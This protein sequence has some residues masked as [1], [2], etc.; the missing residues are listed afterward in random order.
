MSI[1]TKHFGYKREKGQNPY[2]GF[3]SF[4]HFRGE[5]LYSDIVVDPCGNGTETERVECYPVSPDAEE[6]GREQGYYPDST[7]VYIRILW[8]EFEPK[9]GEY[10]YKFIEEI[11]EK[12]K[13]S[14]QKM[15][16]RL[17]AHSTRAMDDVPSWLKEIVDCPERPDGMRVKDSPADPLFVELFLK[18]VR[19]F[20]ERFDSCK[21][22]Y[23]VDISLPGAWGEGHNLEMYSENLLEVIVDT[24]TSVFKNTQ[25]MTQLIRPDLIEYGKKSSGADIGWRGDGLGFPKLLNELYPEGIEK[26]R[27]NWKRAPVSFE[28][29]WWLGEWERRGWDID[30]IIEKTL[31]WHISSFNAKSMPVPQKWREKV[32]HWISRMGYHFTVNSLT[33]PENLDKKD[34]LSFD[35]EIENIGVAPVYGNARLELRLICEDISFV[36]PCDTDIRDLLP[37]KH[38]ISPCIA[39]PESLTLGEYCLEIGMR[40]DDG[41]R[42]YLATDAECDGDFYKLADIIIK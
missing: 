8:K 2:T 21:E 15:I 32:D 30:A 17:M 25:L 10:N 18:A 12:V 11:L 27:D 6:G 41:D 38:L 4:Q 13:K 7:V 3:M 28:S 35:L 22:L 5:K 19:S 23:A 37:G 1:I 16:F 39:L 20:G 14:S 24:Y 36:F 42:I 26:I 40:F 9:R 34:G 31:S 29:Y 33:Y